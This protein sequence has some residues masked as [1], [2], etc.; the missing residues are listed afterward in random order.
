MHKRTTTLVTIAVA[1][2]G[3]SACSSSSAAPSASGS[4]SSPIKIMVFGQITG[5]AFAVPEIVTGAQAAVN[6]INAQGG[7]NGRKLQLIT[8]D[9]QGNVNQDVACAREAASDG[10]AAV[11]GTL[12]LTQQQSIPVVTAADIPVVAGSDTGPV[13]RQD[14]DS[15]PVLTSPPIYAGQAA[16]LLAKRVCKH[17]AFLEITT[18]DA[19]AGGVSFGRY[20]A[21]HDPSASKVKVVSVPTGATDISAQMAQVLS[22]GA[23]CLGTALDPTTQLES[24]TAVGKS[25]QNVLISANAP[26]L[27]ASSLKTVGPVA[28]DI[29]VSS[30]FYL[31]PAD[32]P[33]TAEYIA[34]VTKTNPKTPIDTLAESAYDGVLIVALAAKG[35]STVD[36]KTLIT[37]LKKLSDVN[38]GLSPAINFSQP[39]SLSCM[40]QALLTDEFAYHYSNGQYVLSSKTPY[41][42]ESALGC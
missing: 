21:Q 17:P 20:M 41:N 39:N 29:V 5:Q 2:L 16:A 40:P 18:S 15:F 3:L 30:P 4:D 36:G 26:S 31:N 11:V 35:L 25:G 33:Q 6:M 28:N 24:I 8:C 22:G 14:P 19:A 7:V 34:N 9:N 1:A 38:T 32:S 12:T 23:D 27:P 42:V 10:V 37:S 13:Y